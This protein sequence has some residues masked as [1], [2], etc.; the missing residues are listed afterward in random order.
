MGSGLTR[1]TSVKEA[2]LMMAAF[3][4]RG[5]VLYLQR[6]IQHKGFD[7]RVLVVGDQ[8][9]G[10]RRVAAEADWRTNVAVGGKASFHEVTETE[11]VLAIKAA[12]SNQ[13]EIAGVDLIYDTQ[14]P[15]RSMPLVLEV[16][17]S[18]GWEAI[19]QVVDGDVGATVLQYCLV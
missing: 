13:C 7:I 14:S 12:R 15:D 11:R 6:F 17:A 16:N 8:V 1:L 18:P 5:E 4:E 10:M 2:T 3:V 9:F 19:S